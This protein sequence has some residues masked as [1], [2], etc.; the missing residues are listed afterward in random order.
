MRKWGQIHTEVLNVECAKKEAQYLKY[1]LSCAVEQ[2]LLYDCV[3]IPIGI[4]LM[5]SSNV[6]SSLLRQH[7]QLLMNL[8]TFEIYGLFP[9]MLQKIP[10]GNSE[11]IITNINECGMIKR[12]ER[13]P[14]T[15]TKGIWTVVVEKENVEAAKKYLNDLI[16]QC[17]E[18]PKYN[19]KYKSYDR[20]QTQNDSGVES[21]ADFLEKLAAVN[22]DTPNASSTTEYDVCPTLS[23]RKSYR[24]ALT[25]ENVVPSKNVQNGK[26]KSGNEGYTNEGNQK[27]GDTEYVNTLKEKLNELEEKIE[28]M[29][30]ANK[31]ENAIEKALEKY[32]N[33]QEMGYEKINEEGQSKDAVNNEIGGLDE[34]DVHEIIAGHMK[35]FEMKQNEKLNMFQN[36][37]TRMMV[38]EMHTTMASYE[39]KIGEMI[40]N[41]FALSQTMTDKT[42]METEELI[43]QPMAVTP[44]GQKTHSQFPP[45]PGR[46]E[47][48]S[49][50][51]IK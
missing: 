34:E 35:E 7:N 2:K 41:A 18:K 44:N 1:L 31:I 43:T 12:M 37:L 6:L 4:H 42:N 32:R 26:V 23:N 16:P 49:G 28:E 40:A 50:V 45:T 47:V 13:T 25:N 21:Y 51:G 29:T 30:A 9:M 3:F 15:E 8:R 11:S 20:P 27:D 24:S 14:V 19:T 46:N 39:N 48:L 22:E 33:D 17:T 10:E 5:K 36:S 38:K